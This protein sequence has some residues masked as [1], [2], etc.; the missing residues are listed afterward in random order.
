MTFCH[1][2]ADRLCA[3]NMA[4]RYSE[5]MTSGS[6]SVSIPDNSFL[7]I[8]WPETLRKIYAASN[9]SSEEGAAS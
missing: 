6:L 7:A 1:G 8:R 4:L 9:L 3:E 2:R 5:H